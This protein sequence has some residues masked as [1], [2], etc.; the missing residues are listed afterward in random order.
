MGCPKSKFPYAVK[1]QINTLKILKNYILFL[2]STSFFHIV[3]KKIQAFIVSRDLF[4]YARLVELCAKICEIILRENFDFI[5]K[6]LFSTKR[7]LEGCKKC[8][9]GWSKIEGIGRMS[10]YITLKSL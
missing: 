8:K 5:I 7:D 1:N 3:V 9:I 4:L 2:S 10:E 6:K